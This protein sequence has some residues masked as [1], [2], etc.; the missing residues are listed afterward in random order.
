MVYSYA[1][2]HHV[3]GGDT[4]TFTK[5]LLEELPNEPGDYSLTIECEYHTAYSSDLYANMDNSPIQIQF[6]IET[7]YTSVLADYHPITFGGV[8]GKRGLRV[9][10]F[11]ILFVDIF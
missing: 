10:L 9:K 11:F 4:L 6:C 8:K 5:E 7:V 1:Q 2:M 3:Y